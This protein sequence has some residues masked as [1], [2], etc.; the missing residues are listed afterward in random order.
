MA[1]IKSCVRYI[2]NMSYSHISYYEEYLSDDNIKIIGLWLLQK[3]MYTISIEKQSN[4]IFCIAFGINCNIY[5]IS[6]HAFSVLWNSLRTYI[7]KSSFRFHI[8]IWELCK[9][10]IPILRPRQNC[11]NRQF[12]NDVSKCLF[13]NEDLWITNYIQLKCVP[14]GLIDNMPSL[15]QIMVLRRLGDKPSLTNMRHMHHLVSMSSYDN[16][17]NNSFEISK[18]KKHT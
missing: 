2:T 8:Y 6:K 11:R 5:F 12:A 15:V 1:V 13:L 16:D 9:R 17:W 7:Y 10:S 14:Y 4:E 3:C 18:W